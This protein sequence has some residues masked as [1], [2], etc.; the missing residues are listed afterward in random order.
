MTVKMIP[1]S[2]HNF[3]SLTSLYQRPTPCELEGDLCEEGLL[4]VFTGTGKGKT[5]AALGMALRAAG[6]GMRVLIL[7]FIKGGWRYGEL[8][9]VER[10]PEIEIRT[11]GTGFTWKKENLE[12][13][14]VLAQ[15]GWEIAAG[16]LERGEVDLLI[17]DELN[18]VMAYGLLPLEPVL[19]ALRERAPELHVVVTGAMG[20]RNCWISPTWSRKS[21]GQ[22]PYHDQG[23][24]AQ[25]GVEF[26]RGQDSGDGVLT[27][28]GRSHREL[29]VFTKERQLHQLYQEIQGD[30]RYRNDR[31]GTIV[32]GGGGCACIGSLR[33]GGTGT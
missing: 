3:A 29:M 20:H 31:M 25:K 28:R 4:I 30:D 15:Q 18:I 7:Q 19:R 22:D 12:E 26:D 10:F 2:F 32:P 23:I 5:T 1:V 16:V 14:R 6:H 24:V 8:D 17:L 9:A 33:R 27:I 11:L 13:D 21:A